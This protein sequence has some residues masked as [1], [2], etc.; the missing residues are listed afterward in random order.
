MDASALSALIIAGILAIER[1]L[2][3]VKKCNSGCVSVEM[4]KEPNEPS[5]PKNSE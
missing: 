3:K 1:I 2:S 4:K 5:S